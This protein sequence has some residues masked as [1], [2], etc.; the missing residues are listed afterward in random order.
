MKV[1]K[2]PSNLSVSFLLVGGLMSLIAWSLVGLGPTVGTPPSLEPIIYPPYSM[3]VPTKNF[4]LL[5]IILNCL[6]LSNNTV[7]LSSNWLIDVACTSISSTLLWVPT[8]PSRANSHVGLVSLFCIF[9]VYQEKGNSTKISNVS[10]Y[11]K[12]SSGNI[13]F[14]FNSH[15]YY[16]F[17]DQNE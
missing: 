6:S 5:A 10:L 14:N 15:K 1:R 13:N 17:Q 2:R 12:A 8:T 11:F 16:G 7:S 9:K 3:T 4:L